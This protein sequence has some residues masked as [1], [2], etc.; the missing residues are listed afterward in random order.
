MFLVIHLSL[1]GFSSKREIAV[2]GILYQL[3][4]HLDY[5]SQKIIE[6]IPKFLLKSLFKVSFPCWESR[7]LSRTRRAKGEKHKTRRNK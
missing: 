2:I 1:S 7:K 5:Y 6:V 4:K 3:F